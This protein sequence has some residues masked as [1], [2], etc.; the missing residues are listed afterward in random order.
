MNECDLSNAL[1]EVAAVLDSRS[2][3]LSL[4]PTC[5]L[6]SPVVHRRLMWRSPIQKSGSVRKRKKMIYKRSR[7]MIWKMFK[8]SDWR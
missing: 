6:V 4:S 7:P 5:L 8:T 2:Q 3:R 1:E